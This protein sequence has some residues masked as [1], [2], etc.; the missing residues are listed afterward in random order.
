[1]IEKEKEFAESFNKS[2]EAIKYFEQLL[3]SPRSS[4]DTIGL[5]YISTEEGE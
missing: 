3:R 2:N 5:D 1:M 4:R